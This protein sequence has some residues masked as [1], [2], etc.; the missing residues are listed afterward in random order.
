MEK[1]K[2]NKIEI[3]KYDTDVLGALAI[4]IRKSV[5]ETIINANSGHLGGNSSSVELLTCLYFGGILKFD[6]NNPRDENRDRVLIRGHEGPVRYKI[7]SL[8]GLFPETELRTYRQF[9]SILQGHEDMHTTP[10]VDITPSGSLGMILSYGVGSAIAAKEKRLTYRTFVFLGDGEEQ[11]GN[12]S[13]AARHA[14]NLGLNNLVCILDKNDKQLSRPT[15]ESDG[16]TDIKKIWEGY[17]W[18]VLEITNGHDI[19]E[20]MEVYSKLEYAKKPSFIIAHTIKGKD[21]PGTEKNFSGYHTLSVCPRP[22]AEQA[23]ELAVKEVE[24]H[25]K[26]VETAKLLAPELVVRPDNSSQ[27]HSKNSEFVEVNVEVNPSNVS[28]L[29]Y[30][31]GHYFEELRKITENSRKM[32][33]YVI[34]PD[35]IRKDLVEWVSFPDFTKFLDCGIREQHSIAMAHGI[36]ISDPPARIFVNF[37][38]AFIYRAIDQLNAAAQGGSKMIIV[39][40]YSG[41]TQERNGKTHQTSGQPG[42][43]IYMPGLIIKEPADVQ[44][45]Y[46]VLNWAFTNNPGAVYTRIHRKNITPLY[47]EEKDKGNIGS[48]ITHDPGKK[49][50]LVIVS[51]G[52][53]T[54]NSVRAAQLLETEYNLPTRVVNVIGLN[55]L[56]EEFIRLLENDTPLLTVYNGSGKILQSVV[57]LAVMESTIL[58]PSTINGVGFEFGTSGSIEE[59]EAHFKLDDKGIVSTARDLFVKI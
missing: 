36:S 22:I 58:R 54:H 10:G 42:A 41:L 39:G 1:L 40:E 9:G 4:G 21:I 7:F 15:H 23:L 24:M 3:E 13:E 44:D 51:S 29:D 43:L 52:F 25:K 56:G 31:Q 33:I 17:G 53:T 38:D 19:D 57:S 26:E 55:K 27:T 50:K 16:G 35:F 18:E 37:G 8:M 45:L 2:A 12:V 5:F 48:Y 59:L 32:R 14:S 28:N 47:R 46:N 30:S 20:I 6:C 11:E 34:T 49:P